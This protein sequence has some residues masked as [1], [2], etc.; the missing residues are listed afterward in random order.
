[1]VLDSSVALSW[2]FED[3]HTRAGLAI[4]EKV[5]ED[6]AVAPAIWPLEVL[7]GLLMAQRRNRLDAAQRIRM[8]GLL[9]ALPVSIDA[10]MAAQ[11]WTETARLAERFRLTLYDAAYLELAARRAL[12]LASLDRSLRRAATALGTD[13]IET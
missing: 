6:G 13:L 10:D 11:A 3:E 4:L 12:P 9:K 1:M 5:A 7:N 2:C 8:T